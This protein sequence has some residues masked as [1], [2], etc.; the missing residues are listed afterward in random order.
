MPGTFA[1]ALT[2]IGFTLLL[3][4]AHR[5]TT[6]TTV[7]LVDSRAMASAN[8]KAT[9]HL[10]FDAVSLQASLARGYRLGLVGIG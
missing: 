4:A 1:P 9:W 2:S 8:R 5:H 10:V 3:T 6:H 7:A